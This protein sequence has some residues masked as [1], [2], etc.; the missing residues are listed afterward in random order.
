MKHHA[1][2][3]AQ[4]AERYILVKDI[5]AQDRDF[6]R[7]GDVAIPFVDAIET[8]Q[9]GGL[10]AARR[11]D[12]SGHHAPFDVDHLRALVLYANVY[13]DRESVES[14]VKNSLNLKELN[15]VLD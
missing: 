1:D 9:Q 11:T 14:Y 2:A 4:F 8:A 13:G 7:G 10:A 3:F 15:N 5:L 6:P 12:Q